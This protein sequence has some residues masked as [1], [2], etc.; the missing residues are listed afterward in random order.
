[1]KTEVVKV[2]PELATKWL[3]GNTHNRPVR[4]T[5]VHQ[6]AQDMRAGRWRLTH[7]GIAFASD[8]SLIDGQHRLWAI[9]EAQVPVE[10]SVSRGMDP[11]SQQYID[12]GLPRTVVD[13]LRLSDP[14]SGVSNFRAAVARRMLIGTRT[15]VIT[16]RQ[17]II[18]FLTQHEKALVF[19]IEDALQK[20]RVMRVT[21]AAVPAAI[22]RAYYHE[23]HARL[24]E[25]GA[26]LL[27][28]IPQGKSDIGAHLLRD[29][30]LAGTPTYG[31]KIS[32]ETLIYMKTQR[33][34]VAFL[35]GEQLRSLYPMKDEA[36]ALKGE[37]RR[38]QR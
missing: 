27:G 9:I 5:R 15:Q 3:E 22:A 18:E 7:Q 14:D 20:K 33:A 19:A 29:W 12:E 30:L 38:R 2:T 1:M 8:G 10:V 24:R 17:E 16:G 32:R 37:I 28:S 13:V 11:E 6:Y 23:D 25:F 36:W 26:V 4:D 21:P 35:R 34:I 31:I